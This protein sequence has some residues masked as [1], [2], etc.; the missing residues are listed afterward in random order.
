MRPLSPYALLVVAVVVAA[1]CGGRQAADPF[2]GSPGGEEGPKMSTHFVRF[3]ANCDACTLTWRVLDRSGSDVDSGA[4]SRQVTL[5]LRPGE[6]TEAVLRA[7]PNPRSGPVR[8][9]RIYVDGKLA[10]ETRVDDTDEQQ[11]PE[12]VQGPVV[13][14]AVIPQPDFGTGAGGEPAGG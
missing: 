4:Y 7:Q 11:L 12:R 1:G 5:H 10:G 13:V 6:T 8:Y 2:R 14:S 3:E 9:V